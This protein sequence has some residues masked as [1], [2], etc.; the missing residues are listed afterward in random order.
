MTTA[1]V[2]TMLTGIVVFA[3]GMYI[4]KKEEKNN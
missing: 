1:W 2:I 4:G 3:Y